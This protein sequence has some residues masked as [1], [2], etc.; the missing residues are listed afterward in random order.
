MK[1]SVPGSNKQTNRAEPNWCLKIPSFIAEKF[2]VLAQAVKNLPANAG[3]L[4]SILGLG[5]SRE[6]NGNPLHYS[7]LEDPHGQKRLAGYSPWGSQSWT[8][9]KQL[10]T[11]NN[12][13]NMKMHGLQLIQLI[14]FQVETEV[15]TKEKWNSLALAHLLFGGCN[16]TYSS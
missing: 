8:W 5:R 7:C 9:L 6:G 13:H 15:V 3:N 10:S 11:K 16:F 14:S 1:S 2:T 4:S 12:S